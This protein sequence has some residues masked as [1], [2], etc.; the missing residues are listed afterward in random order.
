MK[1]DRDQ[2]EK[3][4]SQSKGKKENDDSDGSPF[5][6]DVLLNKIKTKYIANLIM[7]IPLES[8]H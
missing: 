2:E 3:D 4:I 8:G 6:N 5:K 7:D 1:T